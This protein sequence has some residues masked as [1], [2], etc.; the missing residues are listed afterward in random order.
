M[1]TTLLALA[2]TAPVAHATQVNPALHGPPDGFGVGVV[3]GDPSGLSLAFRPGDPWFIQAA[4]GWSLVRDSLHVSADYCMNVVILDTPDLPR[5]RFPVYV[6]VGGRLRLG[7]NGGRWDDDEP[8]LGVRV[9]VG[10]T[11]LPTDVPIDVF[12]EIVPVLQLFPETDGTLD[13]GIGARFYF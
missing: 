7:E 2:L 8:G 4:A 3:L 12:V 9:P 5:M 10:M 1:L 13:G 6:G 11:L